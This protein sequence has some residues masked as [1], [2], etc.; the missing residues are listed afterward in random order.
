[1]IDRNWHNIK[2]LHQ[3]TAQYYTFSS[4]SHGTFNKSDHRL[5]NKQ[6]STSIKYSAIWHMFAAHS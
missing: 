4:S 6:V 1:M 2:T 5:G 3:I